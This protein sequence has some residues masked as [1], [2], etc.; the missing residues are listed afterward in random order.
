MKTQMM[1]VKAS[2]LPKVKDIGHLRF[3]AITTIIE[4]D[5]KGNCKMVIRDKMVLP[6]SKKQ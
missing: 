5:K 6:S 2:R 1:Q 3:M 4:A